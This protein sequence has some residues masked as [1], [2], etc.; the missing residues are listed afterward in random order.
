MA[1]QLQRALA[2][3]LK[4]S[5]V[6]TSAQDGQY[7]GPQEVSADEVRAVYNI[8]GAGYGAAEPFYN[9]ALF[10][11]RPVSGAEGETAEILV[12]EDKA[13]RVL[14]FYVQIEAQDGSPTKIARQGVVLQRRVRVEGLTTTQ[15]LPI[16]AVA[17]QLAGGNTYVFGPGRRT[18]EGSPGG[19]FPV[20]ST[21]FVYRGG[22]GTD[23][24]VRGVYPEGQSLEAFFQY[25]NANQGT[26][27]AISA[28]VSGLE[29]PPNTEIP[30]E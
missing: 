7:A 1:E 25:D 30:S 14:S 10:A 16:E 3:A 11:E 4:N 24:A 22:F 5:I 2:E 9:T 29:V 21:G 18:V 19:N 26:D 23:D 17:I 6:R 27:I 12:P 15:P 20:D 8:E 28:Y 13:V